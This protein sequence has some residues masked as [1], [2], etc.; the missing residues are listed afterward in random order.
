MGRRPPVPEGTSHRTDTWQVMTGRNPTFELSEERG[1]VE[2]MNHL[3]HR[4]RG[5]TPTLFYLTRAWRQL[6]CMR[7]LLRTRRRAPSSASVISNTM[8]GTR[9]SSFPLNFTLAWCVFPIVATTCGSSILTNDC[10]NLR[11]SSLCPS[12][13]LPNVDSCT[14]SCCRVPYEKSSGMARV[15]WSG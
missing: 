11:S 5:R 12:S 15:V 6:D 9:L 1:F 13:R 10:S 8:P 4:M 14:F 2:L 3:A 7:R